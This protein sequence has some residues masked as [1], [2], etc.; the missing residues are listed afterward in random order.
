MKTEGE[1]KLPTVVDVITTQNPHALKFVLNKKLIRNNVRSF[2]NINEA[3]EDPLANELFNIEGIVSVW[4]SERFVTLE[5]KKEV[6]WGNV[7]KSL[8]EIMQN[9]DLE[10]LHQIEESKNDFPPLIKK[11]EEIIKEKIIPFLSND[12]GSINI[13]DYGENKIKLKFIGACSGCAFANQS[14]ITMIKKTLSKEM[15]EQLEVEII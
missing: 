15:P 7:Q 8:V 5:K 9:F 4:Y 1:N 10:K 3:K 12:G 6:P 14:T 13:I 11:A 2:D